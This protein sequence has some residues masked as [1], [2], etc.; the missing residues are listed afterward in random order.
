MN[1]LRLLSL[2]KIE[3]IEETG[4]VSEKN[5]NK[6]IL[7]PLSNYSHPT[8]ATH[9]N[10]SSQIFLWIHFDH[11][12]NREPGWR[13]GKLVSG[14]LWQTE[15]WD[16]DPVYHFHRYLLDATNFS[17]G[18]ISP[19]SLSEQFADSPPLYP[20]TIDV[21]QT[22]PSLTQLREGKFTTIIDIL[23][24][25]PEYAE[26]P[27]WHQ[28]ERNPGSNTRMV[29]KRFGFYPHVVRKN[30]VF[31]SLRHGFFISGVVNNLVT[32]HFD[33]QECMR[34]VNYLGR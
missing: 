29:R 20:P 7:L 17:H 30:L 32:S 12:K 16:N 6:N 33:V 31:H 8:Y 14:Y 18:L 22:Y 10:N 24:E 13:L 4:E 26:V 9:P 5:R 25:R 15:D 11:I 34:W 28:Q 2:R 3:I 27:L 21:E 1:K 19:T 23:N